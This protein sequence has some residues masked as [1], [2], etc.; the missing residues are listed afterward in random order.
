MY[1]PALSR[2]LSFHEFAVGQ[3]VGYKYGFRFIFTPVFLLT[4]SL[5]DYYLLYT[6]YIDREKYAVK[7]NEL[8]K[9]LSRT[10]KGSC[11]ELD[12]LT[13][14]DVMICVICLAVGYK[15]I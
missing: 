9:Q 7:K 12:D 10:I 13:L 6:V 5:T 14:I 2:N 8:P 15:T 11:Q 3:T 4:N 1:C